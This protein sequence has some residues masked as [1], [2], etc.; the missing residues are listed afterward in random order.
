MVSSFL[1]APAG[2]KLQR[3]EPEQT[4]EGLARRVRRSESALLCYLGYA[5]VE[6]ASGAQ[7]IS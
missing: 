2:A 5:S 4:H 6:A 1:A 3:C 7:K